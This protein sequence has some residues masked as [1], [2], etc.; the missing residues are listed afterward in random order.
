MPDDTPRWRRRKTARPG[1]ILEAALAVFAEQGFAAAKLEEIARRAG[2]SKAA[3][4]LYFETKEDL[5]RAVAGGLVA[6]NLGDVARGLEASEATF[7]ELAPVLL[8]RAAAVLSQPAALGVLRMVLAESRNFPDL[9]RIWRENAV[10]QILG[11]VAGLIARAQRSDEVIAGDPRLLAFSLMGPVVM[12]GFFHVVF[13]EDAPG[14]P[15]LAVLAQQH[16]RTVLAGMIQQPGK[17]EQKP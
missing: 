13:G 4:Y 17:T 3:L 9:A 6:T 11:L 1:E 16:A 15:D 14:A 7:A 8:G 10:E 12:G 5:F 2:I